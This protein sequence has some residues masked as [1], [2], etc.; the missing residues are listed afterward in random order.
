MAFTIFYDGQCPLCVKEMK[1]LWALNH[2]NALAFIDIHKL[3][4]HPQFQSICFDKANKILHGVTPDGTLMLGLDVTYQAWHAVGKGHWV[5]PLQWKW[6]RI[7]A[8]PLYLLFA[9]NRFVISRWL[10]GEERC[11]GHCTW[12][13]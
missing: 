6:L 8:D 4:E 10:T 13:K 2:N 7:I 5:A 11:E 9:R 1:N 12:K 3:D